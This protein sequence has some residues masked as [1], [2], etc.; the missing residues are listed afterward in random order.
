MA[1]LKGI[2]PKCTSNLIKIFSKYNSKQMKQLAI[3]LFI[4]MSTVLHGQTT[5]KLQEIIKLG[6]EWKFEEAIDKLKSEIRINPE[7]PELYYW[8]GRYS[9]YLVYDTRPFTNKGNLWSKE[10]V[11]K[12]FQKAVE[13]DPNYGDAKYFLAVEYGARALEALKSGDVEQYKKELSDAKSWGAFPSHAIEYGKN[14]LRSCDTN[15][16]LIVN[17]DADFNILQYVQNIEGYRK[18][19]SLIVVALLERPYYIKLIRDGV[20]NIYKPVPLSMNDNLIMEMHNYKWKENDVIIPISK[21]ARKE[22]NLNDTITNLKWH[23]KP[24]VGEKKLWVGTAILLNIIETNK[25]DRP[26]HCSLFVYKNFIGLIEN[27]QTHGLTAQIKPYKVKGTKQ[28]YNIEKFESLMFDPNYYKDYPDIKINNQP[29]ASGAF[30]HLSRSMIYYY[31][32]YLYRNGEIEKAKEALKK[33]N[34][35]M[36]PETFPFSSNM[37]IRLKGLQTVLEK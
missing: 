28:E 30:G 12:N 18:D 34:E 13:L 35:L 31:A 24:D 16:I 22:Y 37:K 36:P 7:N 14:I 8:L 15:A 6:E 33:M 3:F 21:Q 10:Q 29:R 2:H 1:S 32:A 4:T 27:L 26:I 25:W 9:H 20:P 17:G 5:N 23:I 11:L 19:V